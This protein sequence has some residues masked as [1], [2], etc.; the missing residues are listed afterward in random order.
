LKTAAAFGVTAMTA[1]TAVTAQ[2]AARVHAIHP[3]P[4]SVIRDQIL[5]VLADIGADAIK[6]GMLGTAEA[7]DSVAGAL[8]AHAANIPLVLDPVLASTSGTPLL[9]ENAI[10]VLKARLFP[11]A[12]LLTPNIPEAERLTGTT[13]G[14]RDGM[15][16]AAQL[17]R[18][19]GAQAVLV[20]G[21]HTQG[22]R[23][24]DL[25]VTDD[26]IQ[27][28]DNPRIPGRTLRG[29]GC[30]LA[31]AIACGLAQQLS[32][33]ESVRQARRFVQAAIESAP[34]FGSGEELREHCGEG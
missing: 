9:A 23:V 7:A 1:V 15:L 18:A 3:I 8:E 6:I 13:I 10:E 19:L 24:R 34:G 31:S 5:C 27:E 29:T 4:S 25:L 33:A 22:A 16:R 20:K 30:M 32:L 17:L 14:D 21:G 28:F 26:G 11:L 12:A 2:D